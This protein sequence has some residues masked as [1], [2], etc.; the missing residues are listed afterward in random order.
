MSDNSEIRDDKLKGLKNKLISNAR[1][2]ITEEVGLSIGASKMRNIILWLEP[3]E[4]VKTKNLYVFKEYN[5]ET[6][7]IPSGS[8]RLYCS[9]EAFERYEKDLNFFNQ[10]YR[11]RILEACFEIIEEYAE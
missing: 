3:Y 7:F 2:I 1:A 10:K 8:A 5:K 9:K 4:V 6:Q 11:N